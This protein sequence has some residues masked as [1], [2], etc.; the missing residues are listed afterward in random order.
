MVLLNALV[1]LPKFVLVNDSFFPILNSKLN[2]Q[3]ISFTLDKGNLL[4]GLGLL[5]DLFMLGGGGGGNSSLS[6]MCELE[7]VLSGGPLGKVSSSYGFFGSFLC[8]IGVE[9]G[10]LG[11]S[12]L[13]SLLGLDLALSLLG[14]LWS[15][16]C[17]LFIGRINIPLW[18]DLAVLGG[19]LELFSGL[20]NLLFNTSEC[21][22]IF[23]SMLL[24]F[25]FSLLI[26]LGHLFSVVQFV[27]LSIN[28][29]ISSNEIHADSNKGGVG[30]IRIVMGKSGGIGYI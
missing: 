11:I 21:S 27:L 15:S 10:S 1:G 5:L 4:F 2:S 24:S 16:A 26:N 25:F 22:F 23:I 30:S 9:L 12:S 20:V 14:E 6:F 28:L 7:N 18:L 29:N 8:F 19:I 13:L 17:A 3:V